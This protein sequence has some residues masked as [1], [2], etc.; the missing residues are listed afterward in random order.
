MPVKLNFPSSIKTPLKLENN[1][2]YWVVNKLTNIKKIFGIDDSKL[3]VTYTTSIENYVDCMKN[4]KTFVTIDA[5][6]SRI[7]NLKNYLL[8]I[9]VINNNNLVESINN[10]Y[11]YQSIEKKIYNNIISKYNETIDDLKKLKSPNSDNNTINESIDNIIKY[12]IFLYSEYDDYITYEQQKNIFILILRYMYY[13]N[14]NLKTKFEKLSKLKNKILEIYNIDK[15]NKIDIKLCDMIDK[16]TEET[17]FLSIKNNCDIIKNIFDY[18]NIFCNE[19]Q[20]KLYICDIFKKI[21]NNA[22]ILNDITNMNIDKYM[23]ENEF[24]KLLES[25]FYNTFIQLET[26]YS[27]NIEEDI[28]QTLIDEFSYNIGNLTLKVISPQLF[29]ANATTGNR[30]TAK[31][32]DIY[33]K[34][35]NKGYYC[36]INEFES[37]NIKLILNNYISYIV[38]IN[39]NRN[40]LISLMNKIYIKINLDI[41]EYNSLINIKDILENLKSSL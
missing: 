4:E 6:E 8:F 10:I 12:I 38:D 22:N 23:N 26:N 14:N 18:E 36:N 35:D 32:I 2:F 3:N 9:N 37:D 30:I 1:F 20:T 5:T 16:K 13:N 19:Q 27:I 28:K 7:R 39:N 29:D 40:K 17:Y 11:D 15:K 31:N 33:S 41:N 25:T 21:L 24:K 34:L